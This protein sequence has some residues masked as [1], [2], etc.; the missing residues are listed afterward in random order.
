[1]FNKNKQSFG[2]QHL[3]IHSCRSNLY[4][5]NSY[6]TLRYIDTTRADQTTNYTWRSIISSG[7]C[8]GLECSASVCQNCWIVHC[9]QATDKNSAVSDIFQRRLNMIVPV[10][11]VAV[12]ADTW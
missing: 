6:I 9:V 12:T 2:R 3:Q 10:V 11:T 1:M 8:T 4:Q 5:T 7:R